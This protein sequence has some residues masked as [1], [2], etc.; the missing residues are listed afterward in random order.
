MHESEPDDDP[1]VLRLAASVVDGRQIDWVDESAQG[2]PS[3]RG[4]SARPLDGLRLV[5]DV[6]DAFRRQRAEGE[7]D[8]DST[9]A[10]RLFRWGRLDVL[11]RLGEGG[12]GQVYRA[13]DPQL[14]R[15]VALKLQRQT[16]DAG[17]LRALGEAR[18]LARIRHPN[19]LTVHGV[20]VHDGRAGLWTDLLEGRTLHDLV[21]SSGPLSAHEAAGVGV[22]LCRALAA[23]H[24]AGL[25][26]GDVKPGNVMREVG[27]RIVLMDFGA[28]RE[29][30]V[31]FGRLVEATTVT[32]APEVLAG[33]A[34]TPS[35]DLYSLGATLFFLVCGRYPFAPP[36]SERARPRLRD[37]R[38]DLPSELVEVIE[39]ALQPDPALRPSSAGELEASLRRAGGVSSP[40][41]AAEPAGDGR[42]ARGGRMLPRIAAAGLALAVLIALAVLLVPRQ[43]AGRGALSSMRIEGQR[44]ISDF[45]G[46]SRAAS[47]SPDGGMI[48]F[49]NDR[50]GVDQV[51]VRPVD[52]G[53]PI[54]V[55]SGERAAGRP[56][57][58]SRGEIVYAR[59][60]DGV[61]AVA[62]L[63]G[64]PRR[65]LEDGTS[66]DVSFDGS[67]VVFQ[68]LNGLWLADLDSGIQERLEAVPAWFF[69]DVDAS[70][71]FARDG[72]V[73]AYFQQ[74]EGPFG[75]LF[76]VD[77]V[78]GA[79]RRLTFDLTAA[80][81]PVFTPDGEAIVF[82]SMRSGSRLLWRVARDGGEPELV[83]SGAGEDSEATLSG[84]GRRLAFTNVR[85]RS[86][87]EVLD[88]RTRSRRE[89]LESRALL[90]HPRVSPAGDRIAYFQQL[91]TAGIHIFVV[92]SAGGDPLQ[93]TSNPGGQNIHPRWSPDGLYLYYYDSRGLT[94]RRMPAAGGPSEEVF[95]NWHMQ[96]QNHAEISPDGTRVLYTELGVE[97]ERTWIRRLG[98]AGEPS[99]LP[100]PHLHQAQ[101]TPDGHSVVGWRHD[102][103]AYECIVAEGECR[104]I[105]ER[106]QR[107]RLDASGLGIYFHRP[108]DE[109]GYWRL[110]YRDLAGGAEREIGTFGPYDPLAA[111]FSVSPGDEIVSTRFESGR[112]ELWLA[113]LR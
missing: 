51:W 74:I 111:T 20:D 84:D 58:S 64:Q 70:P 76:L 98:G 65:L 31:A 15:Q 107:P 50:T 100:L 67:R 63:G 60:G 91:G 106:G 7:P 90:A 110:F 94:F 42:V 85:H 11:E 59:S 17:V 6:A 109:A 92:P 14:D 45:P 18:R 25:V 12:Y 82:S 83:T 49:L 9:L 101:W 39:G 48:A 71:A 89:V 2:G 99:G 26:H 13:Y 29:Q 80:G 112:R 43:R 62:P 38:A 41:A 79:R 46:S 10:L 108:A 44:L 72:S 40:V 95:A 3:D 96:R 47:F 53:A 5:A 93:L 113:T 34:P 8:H 97:N 30:Q 19:V 102:G 75:D 87:L 73:V 86:V 81:D 4:D 28:A 55:T 69:S 35:A 32:A 33:A 16:A 78:D 77:L 36:E 104:R 56:R 54:Q 88:P 37:L 21:E 68:K 61:W 23:I 1:V 22:D 52:G 66:P 103:H 105:A 27:G 24:N 57:W